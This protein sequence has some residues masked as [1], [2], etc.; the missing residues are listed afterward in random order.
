MGLKSA[1]KRVAGKFENHKQ[2]KNIEK[3]GRKVWDFHK[4]V[5]KNFNGARKLDNNHFRGE[6]LDGVRNQSLRV[7]PTNESVR[8][9]K[10][11]RTVVLK[12]VVNSNGTPTWETTKEI[13]EKHVSKEDIKNLYMEFKCLELYLSEEVE[14]FNEKISEFNNSGKKMTKEEVKKLKKARNKLKD[15]ERKYEKSSKQVEKIIKDFLKI[16]KESE[17]SSKKTENN[18]GNTG[19]KNKLEHKPVMESVYDGDDEELDDEESD[20]DSDE[21][22]E[23]LDDEELDDNKRKNNKGKKKEEASKPSADDGY[24]GDGEGL[25][26]GDEDPDEED[27]ESDEDSDEDDEDENDEESDEDNDGDDGEEND[28]E[29]GDEDGGDEELDTGDV[30]G[31]EEYI[32]DSEKKFRSLPNDRVKNYI[33]NVEKSKKELKKLRETLGLHKNNEEA[34]NLCEEIDSTLGDIDKDLLKIS[35]ETDDGGASAEKLTWLEEINSELQALCKKADAK[36]NEITAKMLESYANPTSSSKPEVGEGKDSKVDGMDEDGDKPE[37]HSEKEIEEAEKEDEATEGEEKDVADKAQDV[38]E[39]AQDALEEAQDVAGKAGWFGRVWKSV[40][41]FGN[42]IFGSSEGDED[43]DKVEIEMEG[44]KEQTEQVEGIAGIMKDAEELLKKLREQRTQIMGEKRHLFKEPDK[45]IEEINSVISKF[46]RILLGIRSTSSVNTAERKS[47]NLSKVIEE[48]KELYDKISKQLENPA[49]QDDSSKPLEEQPL[50]PDPFEELRKSYVKHITDIVVN[51]GNMQQSIYNNAAV[52]GGLSDVERNEIK[53]K[54]DDI[55]NDMKVKKQAFEDVL[56]GATK[57]EADI[58]E[59]FDSLFAWLK[60]ADKELNKILEEISKKSGE[61][62]PPPL[63]RSDG[64]NKAGNA[65]RRR[66][67]SGETL[68][69]RNATTQKH[70]VD[71]EDE[72]ATAV[73]RKGKVASPNPRPLPNPPLPPRDGNNKAGNASRRKSLSDLRFDPNDTPEET[74]EKLRELGGYAERLKKE[75]ED[76]GL[77]QK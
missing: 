12:N 67:W 56:N 3:F 54:T 60:E 68:S 14:F 59:S 13:L 29:L 5:I 21:D 39:E 38:M 23:E 51:L 20:R 18:S 25:G 16:T 33:G 1:F 31:E 11:P 72:V 40:K 42:W 73:Q 76:A 58:K 61:K 17:N 50:N 44:L 64:N 41:D 74:Q 63:P 69:Q 8:L 53:R 52:A 45:V 19:S 46:Q 48:A 55:I 47:L 66:S 49:K 24:D 6:I 65:F 7:G 30:D 28:E 32:G 9:M 77:S 34:K 4:E 27:E 36:L 75:Y 15:L 71:S 22:D 35:S 2:R 43:P 57:S 62:T 37:S 10:L 70:S 26:A